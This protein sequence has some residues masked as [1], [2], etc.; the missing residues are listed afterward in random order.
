MGNYYTKVEYYY[1][2]QNSPKHNGIFTNHLA[3]KNEFL[4]LK[5]SSYSD[6]KNIEDNVLIDHS[7]FWQSGKIPN[8]NFTVT[9]LHSMVKLHSISLKSCD[10]VNCIDSFDVAASNNNESTEWDHICSIRENDDTF[11]RKITNVECKSN[12]FYTS[13]KLT[14][15]RRPDD[16]IYS[17]YFSIHFLEF[18]GNVID[19][20]LPPGSIQVS[21]KTLFFVPLFCTFLFSK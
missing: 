15:V 19:Q 14:H 13:Y 9:F 10:T 8:S 12:L 17:N 4:Y 5:G 11:Y 20:T 7:K 3:N 21:I 16:T 2:T 1:H 6:P 18:F